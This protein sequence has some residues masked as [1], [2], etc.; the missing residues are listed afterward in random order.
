MSF[1]RLKPP[2]E[3]TNPFSDTRGLINVMDSGAAGDGVTDDTAAF[4]GVINS[5]QARGGGVL[6]MP[7]ATYMIGNPGLVIYDGVTMLG[8]SKTET[9]LKR[10]RGAAIVMITNRY[11][12]EVTGAYDSFGLLGFTIDGNSPEHTVT[13]EQGIGVDIYGFDGVEVD[14][15]IRNM[16][17]SAFETGAHPAATDN[18]GQ[19]QLAQQKP[20]RPP[21]GGRHIRGYLNI[22]NA[23]W[24]EQSLISGG[25]TG[26]ITG[27]TGPRTLTYNASIPANFSIWV[28]LKVGMGTQGVV[29]SYELAEVESFTFDGTG[30][31]V[32][33]KSNLLYAHT[34]GSFDAVKY[35]ADAGFGC[36]M[37]QPV[38]HVDMKIDAE[39]TFL[40]GAGVGQSGNIKYEPLNNHDVHM[41]VTLI[42]CGVGAPSLSFHTFD[43]IH[44]EGYVGDP[45]ARLYG[46]ANAGDSTLTLEILGGKEFY[47]GEN[48]YIGNPGLGTLETKTVAGINGDVLTL[49]TPLAN[50]HAGAA[51]GTVD[52]TLGST[53]LANLVTTTGTVYPNQLIYGTGI[54]QDT[55]VVSVVGANVTISNPASATGTAVAFTA[56]GEQAFMVLSSNVYVREAAF[57]SQR[58]LRLGPMI[59][60]HGDDGLVFSSA[61]DGYLNHRHEVVGFH[62][63]NNVQYGVYVG[64][65]R[66]IDFFG[67]RSYNSGLTDVRLQQVGVQDETVVARVNFFGGGVGTTNLIDGAYK[68]FGCD[69]IDDVNDAWVSVSL[70][71]GG[72]ITQTD[73]GTAYV[74]IASSANYQETVDNSARRFRYA[75][76]VARV[77]GNA[78]TPAVDTTT[79]LSG[80][81]T[82]TD[83]SIALTSAAS[84][85]SGGGTVTV[86]TEKIKY[87]GVSTNTLTG[88]ARGSEG[89]TAASALTGVTVTLNK[90]VAVYRGSTPICEAT[91]TGTAATS[92]T[93]A[94]VSFVDAGGSD[95]AYSVRVRGTNST[96]DITI[97]RLSLQLKG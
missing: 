49:K 20:D 74:G 67:L 92:Q 85:P 41:D 50:T 27:Q 28:G 81:I 59:S 48:I 34:S 33:F 82:A 31:T 62:A 71:P 66:E 37:R 76:V 42:R 77:S 89:T 54:P 17:Y 65:G 68:S 30:G 78:G 47:V 44:M 16:P 64:D 73:P 61:E 3:A 18:V 8:E 36:V 96:E 39:Q 60:E 9:I 45:G 57:T 95:Q 11:A 38:A 24:Q 22:F 88:C 94:W 87:T 14:L 32:T 79:T 75:R 63:K 97:N 91:W 43:G 25:T 12:V 52:M 83:T 19:V 69:G 70:V 23:G 10:V 2:L 90:G 26:L 56:R 7:A 6:Y 58:G 55:T 29:G 84:F 4:Q 80:G 35:W 53:T 40:A 1:T 21:A 46:K 72:S 5:L 93:G 13:H 86:G 15:R 51:A